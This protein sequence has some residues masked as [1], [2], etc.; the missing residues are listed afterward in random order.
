MVFRAVLIA[1]CGMLWSAAAWA[2][3]INSSPTAGSSEAAVFFSGTVA[4][5]DGSVPPDAVLVQEI[6]GGRARDAAWTDTKGHF[7]FK[8]DSGGSG[9]GSADASENPST[10]SDFG[11]PIGNS[12]RYTNP[13]TSSLRDCEVQAVLAGFHSD[14]VSIALKTTLDST[15]IGT[16]VL[17]PVSKGGALIVSAT[18]LEAPASARKAYDKGLSAMKAQKWEAASAEFSKAVSLYP[19]FAVAWYQL[20]VTRQAQKNTSDAVDAWR[21]ALESDSHYVKPYEEL[22]AAAYLSSDWTH[23]AEYSGGWIRL[24]AEDF[25]AAYLYSTFA[26]AKLNNMDAAENMA[27]EGLRIDKDHKLPRLNFLLGLVLLQKHQESESAKYLRAYLE[28]APQAA[29]ADMVRAQLAKLVHTA[30]APAETPAA[31]SPQP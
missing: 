20:G 7:S 27:R 23:L 15:R 19:K 3:A 12:T 25:P 24:D 16:I 29:D 26:N 30:G 17:H 9:N 22:S 10:P 4:M 1:G 14:R 31:V 13:V 5:A 21:R 2:Q 11:K 6:C 18:T 8:I 28:L